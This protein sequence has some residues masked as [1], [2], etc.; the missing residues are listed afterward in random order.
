MDILDAVADG[1]GDFAEVDV[2]GDDQS[3]DHFGQEASAA[4]IGE[5]CCQSSGEGAQSLTGAGGEGT[6]S[7]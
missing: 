1:T 5:G 4:G 2:V 7:H 3:G 6:G